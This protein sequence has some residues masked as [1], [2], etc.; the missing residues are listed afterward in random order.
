[1][2]LAIITIKLLVSWLSYTGKHAAYQNTSSKGS[3][4]YLI[5]MGTL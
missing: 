5:G 1:M 3:L 4:R 2:Q